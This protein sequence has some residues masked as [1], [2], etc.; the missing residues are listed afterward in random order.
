[1]APPFV[2]S[3]PLFCLLASFLLSISFLEKKLIHRL[4]EFRLLILQ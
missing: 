3:I 2:C 4:V 1:V